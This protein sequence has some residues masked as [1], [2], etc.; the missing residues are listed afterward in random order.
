M[1]AAVS[2]WTLSQE[3][4]LAHMVSDTL[5]GIEVVLGSAGGDCMIGDIGANTLMGGDGADVLIGDVATS[6]CAA[7]RNPFLDICLVTILCAYF[8]LS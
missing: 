3:R 6:D 8:Y 7:G 4:V 1:L 2:L 5:A